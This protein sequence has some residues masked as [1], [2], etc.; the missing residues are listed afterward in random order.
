VAA[1]QRPARIRTR[2]NDGFMAP[3]GKRLLKYIS[4]SGKMLF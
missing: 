1:A 2:D 4:I 3:P